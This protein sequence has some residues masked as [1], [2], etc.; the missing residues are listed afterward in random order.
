MERGVDSRAEVTRRWKTSGKDAKYWVEY[1]Y[2][3]EDRRYTFKMK[4]GRSRWG[5]LTVESVLPVR[6]LAEDPRSH[7]I[8]GFEGDLM[9]LW[10]PYVV[11]ALLAFFSWLCHL[12]LNAQRRLIQEG[13]AAPAVITGHKKTKDGNM[14]QY[15]FLQLSGSIAQGKTSPEK[16][17][18]AVGS[19][20]C[21]L[22]EPDRLKNNAIYPLSLVRS[23]HA[24][25]KTPHA[26]IRE[27]KA[28]RLTLLHRVNFPISK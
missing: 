10:L 18:P 19:L 9:P 13:R 24:L 28:G 15:S 12:P 14:V 25:E 6:Y 8:H 2:R 11:A 1:Q 21:V 7:Y 22:Y 26:R 20:V 17:P 27:R 23:V 16:N 4:T 3:I 5:R